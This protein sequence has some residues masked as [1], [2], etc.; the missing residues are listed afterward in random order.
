MLGYSFYEVEL[1]ITTGCYGNRTSAIVDELDKLM[2]I[3]M[4]R[5]TDHLYPNDK[6]KGTVVFRAMGMAIVPTHTSDHYWE[7]ML[8]KVSDANGEYCYA[9]L[10]VRQL[11]MSEPSGA[12]TWRVTSREYDEMSGK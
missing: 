2:T 8:R 6:A 7:H 9:T 1:L 5:G 10:S 4:K 11:M 3:V 12:A